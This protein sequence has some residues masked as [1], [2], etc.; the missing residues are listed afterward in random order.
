MLFRPS[1][2]SPR[3]RSARN[4][5]YSIVI[6][7]VSSLLL[8]VLNSARS[9]CLGY[10]VLKEESNQTHGVVSDKEGQDALESPPSSPTKQTSCTEQV[11]FDNI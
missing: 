8:A 11:R 3:R 6:H 5:M 10:E 1:Y 2:Y 9:R 7:N 4:A